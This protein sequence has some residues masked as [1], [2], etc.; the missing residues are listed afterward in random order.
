MRVL[1]VGSHLELWYSIRYIAARIIL[2]PEGR[3]VNIEYMVYVIVFNAL[4][5]LN[6]LW[7]RRAQRLNRDLARIRQAAAL[8]AYLRSERNEWTEADGE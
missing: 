8:R 1:F 2:T 6:V 3:Y 4:L 5:I 7:F